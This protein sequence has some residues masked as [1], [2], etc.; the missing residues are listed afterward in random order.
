ME[1]EPVRRHAQ[2]LVVIDYSKCGAARK[3]TRTWYAPLPRMPHDSRWSICDFFAC[4]EDVPAWMRSVEL[5]LRYHGQ[6]PFRF[7]RKNRPML[8]L[9]NSVSN[10]K[11]KGMTKR[12]EANDS[13]TK[14]T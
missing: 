13:P 1:T 6:V 9:V 14:C 5:V 2:R 7:D 8:L 3:L 12:L 10:K 4:C 11:P